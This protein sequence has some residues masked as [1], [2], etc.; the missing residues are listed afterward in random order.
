MNRN[1]LGL[2]RCTK[3]AITILAV[4]ALVCN[5]RLAHNQ[6]PFVNLFFFLT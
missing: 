4:Q 3:I 5:D 1:I 2:A 6:P